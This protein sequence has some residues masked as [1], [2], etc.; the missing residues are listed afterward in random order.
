MTKVNRKQLTCS[1]VDCEVRVQITILPN[2][3]EAEAIRRYGLVEGLCNIHSKERT[4]AMLEKAKK[5]AKR[6]SEA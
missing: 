1:K 5:R 4:D 3:T 6:G 2:E